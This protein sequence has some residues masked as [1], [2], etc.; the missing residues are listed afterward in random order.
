MAKYIGLLSSDMRGKVGGV[1][2]SRARGATTLS[3]KALQ[4][5]SQ[6]IWQRN[7]SQ[8]FV[9]ALPAWR[10]LSAANQL[11]WTNTAATV[12][13]TN[14]LGTTWNP[15]GL[16]LWTQCYTYAQIFGYPVP[17]TAPMSLLLPPPIIALELLTGGS[18]VTAY[19]VTGA[20]AATPPY[21]LAMSRPIN[22]G[23][24]YTKSISKIIVEAVYP[25]NH[26]GVSA[27]YFQRYGVHLAT[28]M[29]IACRVTPCYPDVWNS[30]TS[31][32]IP[33]TVQ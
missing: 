22:A 16:Q 33:V 30:G 7:S 18:G 4:S 21:L 11:T 20:G 27:S 24:S 2:F 5:G 19:P 9:A 1:T 13:W 12:V 3:A 17:S 15:T 26:V 29:T 31:L 6:S 10:A 25:G 14:S 28:G 8:G 32:E 23:I